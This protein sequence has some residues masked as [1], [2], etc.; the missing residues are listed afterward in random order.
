VSLALG[1]VSSARAQE[2]RPPEPVTGTWAFDYRHHGASEQ[3]LLDLR[4]LNEKEAGQSGFIQRTRD[5]NGFVL[6]DGTPAR[7]W[8]VGSGVYTLSPAE[9]AMQ[10]RFLAR[11]GVNLVRLHT[12]IA[13][14]Q[15]GA[16][17]SAVD[18]K[19]IDG[20]WRFVAAAKKEGIYTMISPYWAAAKA[21]DGWGIE[22]YSGNAELFGLLFFNETLQR[23]YKEWARA[24]FAQINPHTGIPLAQDPAVAMIQVQNEDSLLHWTTQGIK[25]AQL[26]RLARKF[27][28]WL[29]RKYGSLDAARRAWDG[30]GVE[31]DDFG[32]GRV[33]LALTWAFT[34][35]QAGGMARRIGDQLE[36]YAET[37]RR[38]Y[39]D[40]AA[41]YRDTLGCH[42]LINAC[43]W[44]TAHPITLD[45]VERWTYTAADVIAVNRYYS[46]GTH[47][48]DNSA[49]RIDPGHY[50]SQ[51][52][53]L[54]EPRALPTSLKQVVGYPMIVSEVT[55]TS[56]LVYQSEA[57]FLAAV[58]QSLTGVDAFCWFTAT[59]PEYAVDPCLSYFDVGGQHPLLKFELCV[60]TLMGGFPA[61]ALMFRK[62]YI[63]QGEPVVHEERT[64]SSFWNREPPVIAEDQAFDPNRDRGHRPGSTELRTGADPLAFLVG[65]VEV[66][67]DG[68]PARTSVIDVAR[69]ID[70]PK[71]VIQSVTG[72]VTLDYGGGL[73]TVDSPRAQGACGFLAKAGVIRLS[74][75]A[76]N[77]RNG[78]AAVA[79]VSMD[80]EP[81][82]S[83]R[84]ILVQVVTSARPTGWKTRVA[85]IPGDEG[86]T[87]PQGFQILQIGTAPWRVVNTEI[88][89]VVRNPAVTKATLLDPA[90]YPIEQVQG[91]R[92]ARDF[93]LRLP[94]NTMY[95]VLQ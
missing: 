21:V 54:L 67:Y 58:Y 24:L 91:N 75:I 1:L 26:E 30:A 65:P 49:W 93:A 43:N 42:Q 55:W 79:V 53:A 12:Q 81:I 68:D 28:E 19:E 82:A 34:Q 15:Q 39:G 63:R 36:F 14:K 6:G 20:I 5:G 50:F 44:T 41:F 45:D 13:S 76:I 73:C 40:I 85:Q 90:G 51:K 27:A 57:P 31:G 48:G 69:Y 33:G 9:M 70:H 71:K 3:P 62:G 92:T 46:G 95:L 88:G 17:I 72:E 66:K 77:P 83:S 38:F 11:I 61:A 56:P 94:L 10:A 23:G 52:S 22:G 64:V 86:K 78:Y 8:G 37:Q 87:T 32:K 80:E 47:V 89:L 4:Y 16:P 60:P 59:R 18:L 35:P 84:K 29:A 7:F 25:P 2:A 74:D